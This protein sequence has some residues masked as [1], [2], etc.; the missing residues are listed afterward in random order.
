VKGWWKD[1]YSDIRRHGYVLPTE[2]IPSHKP[3]RPPPNQKGFNDIAKSEILISAL[4]RR[5]KDGFRVMLTWVPPGF[6][7]RRFEPHNHCAPCLDLFVLENSRGGTHVVVVTPLLHPLDKRPFKTFPDFIDFFDEICKGIQS[8]HQRN[9]A[10]RACTTTNIVWTDPPFVHPDDGTEHPYR[11]YFLDFGFSREYQTRDEM[12]GQLRGRNGSAPEHE[13][14]GP[15][16]PFRT[17]IY[18]VGFLVREKFL[19]KFQG[20]GPMRDL[21]EEMTFPE[22]WGRP[23]IEQVV[24]T[25][26]PIRQLLGAD[27]LRPLR[28]SWWWRWL[29]W[30]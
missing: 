18:N 1:S 4:A 14:G 19:D 17:D 26:A 29:F 8:M 13:L 30:A 12:D 15:C 9:I 11:Y 7:P 6:K 5:E 16:N 24:N 25:F 3:S 2:F 20:F 28:P 27:G 21:V 22:P 23:L 10:Y